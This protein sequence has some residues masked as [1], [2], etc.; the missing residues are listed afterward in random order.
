MTLIASRAS[1]I[2]S[3]NTPSSNV[4]VNSTVMVRVSRVP[5]L[6]PATADKFTLSAR[7]SK[8]QPSLSS[9][10]MRVVSA[11]ASGL[12]VTCTILE[13]A[14]A[15]RTASSILS[16][17]GFPPSVG[18]SALVLEVEYHNNRGSQ[19]EYQG[20]ILIVDRSYVKLILGNQ[21]YSLL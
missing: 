14:I 21:K 10:S 16:R 11:V 17:I 7:V 20:T 2:C 8:T 4:V 3:M 1:F 19:N 5:H 18:L 15:L 9:S 13:P 12:K 6:E